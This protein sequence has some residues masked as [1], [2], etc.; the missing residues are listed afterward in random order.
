M[1]TPGNEG[2]KK[3]W[4]K[5]DSTDG[6]SLL[7]VPDDGQHGHDEADEDMHD[8]TEGDQASRQGGPRRVARHFRQDAG[9]VREVL[10]CDVTCRT[11]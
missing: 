3:R 11:G 1:R 7:V 5:T 10:L 6:C 9:R 4:K 2:T 8:A